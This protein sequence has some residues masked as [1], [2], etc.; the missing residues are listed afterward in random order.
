MNFIQRLL[1]VI[2]LVSAAVLILRIIDYV[3]HW[4]FHF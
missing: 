3:H 1:N 2:F 4:M